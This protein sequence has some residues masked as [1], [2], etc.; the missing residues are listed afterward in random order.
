MSSLQD[1][2]LTTNDGDRSM[3]DDRR[4]SCYHSEAGQRQTRENVG[5]HLSGC[6]EKRLPPTKKGQSQRTED[7]KHRLLFCSD[8]AHCNMMI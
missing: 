7:R 3:K 6:V 2:D 8:L 4:N 1:A 5:P